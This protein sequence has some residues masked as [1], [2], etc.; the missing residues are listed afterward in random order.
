MKSSLSCFPFML[1]AF[2]CPKKSLHI[3]SNEDRLCSISWKLYYKTH[4][5]DI[6]VHDPPRT[7]FRVYFEEGIEATYTHLNLQS[8]Q[9]IC[10]KTF[11]FPTQWSW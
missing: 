8:L 2:S 9:N 4:I 11:S 7:D 5:T 1:S 6:Q 3:P 10:Q